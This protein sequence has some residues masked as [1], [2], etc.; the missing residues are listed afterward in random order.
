MYRL[1]SLATLVIV[2]L[3][4]LAQQEKVDY[5]MEYVSKVIDDE[6]AKIK[7]AKIKTAKLPPEKK[8][9]NDGSYVAELH[10]TIETI[11]DSTFAGLFSSTTKASETFKKW[12][13]NC[14]V[15]PDNPHKPLKK[16]V[17]AVS[18]E[19]GKTKYNNLTFADLVNRRLLREFPENMKDLDHALQV[20]VD[21]EFQFPLFD[22]DSGFSNPKHRIK[23]LSDFARVQ[24]T[25][26]LGGLGN[27]SFRAF[28]YTPAE[29]AD[30]NNN[31]GFSD[32]MLTNNIVKAHELGILP[33]IQL[34]PDGTSPNKKAFSGDL[35]CCN[36]SSPSHVEYYRKCWDVQPRGCTEVGEYCA[37][38]SY[39]CKTIH[40]HP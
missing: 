40:D 2:S 39:N 12:Y 10:F 29:P 33:I 31:S 3:P 32:S 9:L 36:D 16:A 11:K 21:K 26:N 30:Y 19:L 5:T 34:S 14:K 37:L 6:T 7:T 20:L 18:D 1:L 13:A 25:P 35:C 27:F 28:F 22:L 23:A 24:Q 4:T 17:L 15:L 38:G 8:E